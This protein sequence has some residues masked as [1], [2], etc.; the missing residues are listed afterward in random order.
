VF[1]LFIYTG[2]Y[3]CTALQLELLERR[4][5]REKPFFKLPSNCAFNSLR[6]SGVINLKVQFVFCLSPNNRWLIV[7]HS[8]LSSSSPTLLNRIISFNPNARRGQHQHQYNDITHNQFGAVENGITVTKLM[9]IFSRQA[10]MMDALI[11]H[12]ADQM[13]RRK[14]GTDAVDNV[15]DDGECQLR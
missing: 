11:S 2:S 7:Y 6:P 3:P 4:E 15:A 12:F 13:R 8:L 14:D 10:A 9:Q 1:A 5:A